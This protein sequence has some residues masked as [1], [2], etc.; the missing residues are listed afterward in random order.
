MANDPEDYEA[1]A[2]RGFSRAVQGDTDGA[3]ADLEILD[4]VELPE[5]LAELAEG[6]RGGLS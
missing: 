6:I 4:S 1:L 2:W 3:T 5:P